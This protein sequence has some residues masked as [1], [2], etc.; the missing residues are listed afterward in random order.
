MAAVATAPDPT[1]RSSRRGMVPSLI[2]HP[3]E[4]EAVEVRRARADQARAEMGTSTA[5]GS[6]ASP[7]ALC[8]GSWGYQWCTEMVQPFTQGTAD[9]MF[10]CPNGRS[11]LRRR[12]RMPACPLNAA[13]QSNPFVMIASAAL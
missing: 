12:Q 6:A 13:V 7:A 10:Y 11:Q 9:D 3:H 2:W 1:Q 4:Q 8:E 5:A